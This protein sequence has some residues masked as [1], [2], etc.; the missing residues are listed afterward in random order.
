L[1]NN[2]CF[3]DSTSLCSLDS[4]RGKA[5][6]DGTFERIP[7]A[8]ISR[9]P[10]QARKFRQVLAGSFGHG[11]RLFD[12]LDSIKLNQTQSD[13]SFQS[14]RPANSFFSSSNPTSFYSSLS[15][16]FLSLSP[17]PLPPFSSPLPS[18]V[19]RAAA[20]YV[21]NM[22]DG[23]NLDLS[24]L[25]VLCQMTDI[26]HRNSSSRKMRRQRARQRRKRRSQ[27][28]SSEYSEV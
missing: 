8:E 9:S 23:E 28:P 11:H 20:Q 27:R 4:R 13:S 25:P 18:S 5:V 15:V 12:K 26:I 19:S 22:V 6:E 17:P 21:E 14:D 24:L 2:L 10:D 3:S 1:K 7:R 16:V